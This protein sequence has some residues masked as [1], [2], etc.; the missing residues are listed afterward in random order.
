[1]KVAARKRSP[2]LAPSNG[3]TQQPVAAVKP[4]QADNKLVANKPA[5][6]P[7]SAAKLAASYAAKLTQIKAAKAKAT[8]KKP[9]AEASEANVVSEEKTDTNSNATEAVKVADKK[10]PVTA[11]EKGSVKKTPVTAPEKET[12]KKTPVTAPEKP[13]APVKVSPPT[14]ATK[15]VSTQPKAENKK[16]T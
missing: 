9:A 10:S 5:A 13:K 8:K 16:L 4:L 14:T 15:P 2:I 3:E 6:K 1:M 11:P 7:G 12:V